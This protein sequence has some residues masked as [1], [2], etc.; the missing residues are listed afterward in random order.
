MVNFM[1]L[2]GDNENDDFLFSPVVDF[3]VLIGK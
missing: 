2:D 3:R 1:D